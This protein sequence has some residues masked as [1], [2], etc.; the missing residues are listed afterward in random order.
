MTLFN[1]RQIQIQQIY[2]KHKGFPTWKDNICM[3]FV[4][5]QHQ[6]HLK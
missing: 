1:V 6:V 3:D 2:G 5:G 4:I